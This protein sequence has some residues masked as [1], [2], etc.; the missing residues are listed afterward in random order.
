MI[1][2]CSLWA[3]DASILVTDKT[4]GSPLEFV[5]LIYK[6]LQNKKTLF[7][8]T[9]IKGVAP[10]ISTESSYVT[11]T[12]IGYETIY[13]TIHPGRSY[14]YELEEGSNDLDEIVITA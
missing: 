12:F 3:Q 7:N 8:T 2:S 11:V 14:V 9:S 4:T 13:D 1:A 10:N 6:G 5:H